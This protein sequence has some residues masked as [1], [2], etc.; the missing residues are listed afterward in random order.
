MIK[1]VNYSINSILSENF[2]FQIS[3]NKNHSVQSHTHE[4]IQIVYLFKG[5]IEHKINN[6]KEI[7]RKGDIAIIPPLIKHEIVVDAEDTETVFINFIPSIVNPLFKTH[8]QLLNSCQIDRNYF[9]PLINMIRKNDFRKISISSKNI[10]YIEDLINNIYRKFNEKERLYK[11]AVKADLLEL[12]LIVASEYLSNQG[13]KEEEIY[14][15]IM[16]YRD[17][18]ENAIN[19]INKNYDKEISLNKIVNESLMSTAYFSKAFKLIT[20]K[21]FVQYLNDLRIYHAMSLIKVSNENITTI[22][23]KVGFNDFNHFC[24][25]FKK[26]AGIKPSLF[27]NKITD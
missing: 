23:Y 19:F 15:P 26:I 20:G 2:R 8:L 18:I 12:L 3:K 5:S 11:I 17:N 21:T 24:R 27:R 4:F 16:K 25:T 1:N 14:N 10:D 6:N 7:L 22:C 13:K 9:L